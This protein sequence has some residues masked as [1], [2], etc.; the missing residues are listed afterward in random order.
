MESTAKYIITNRHKIK[1]KNYSIEQIQIARSTKTTQQCES[2]S[3]IQMLL[4]HF[5]FLLRKRE[6]IT[7]K[8]TDLTIADSHIQQASTNKRLCF[9]H[10][11][12]F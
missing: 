8:T 3:Y 6:K 10:I 4:K 2:N 1:E 5:P 12:T 7:S 9:I 11:T